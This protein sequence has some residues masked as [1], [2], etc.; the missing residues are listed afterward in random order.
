MQ[1]F[2]SLGKMGQEGKDDPIELL[3]IRVGSANVGFLECYTCPGFG[4][5][6]WCRGEMLGFSES[7]LEMQQ[8]KCCGEN[9]YIYFYIYI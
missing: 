5:R 9:F 4:L 7:W 6:L 3:G 8:L 1:G 2:D